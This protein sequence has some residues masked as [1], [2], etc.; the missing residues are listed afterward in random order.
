MNQKE[1]DTTVL[2]NFFHEAKH[3]VK[4]EMEI[5]T[6][7]QEIDKIK[8]IVISAECRSNFTGPFKLFRSLSNDN[9]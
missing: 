4:S 3:F 7:D 2:I 8:K 9:F 5:S 1:F 6:P